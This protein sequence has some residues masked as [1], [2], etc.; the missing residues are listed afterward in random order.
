MIEQEPGI[1]SSEWMLIGRQVR[2]D[3][4]GIIDLIAI[5][6]DGSLVVIELKRDRTPRDVLAQALDYATWVERLEAADIARIYR[7]YTKGRSLDADFRERFGAPLEEESLGDSHQIVIVAAQ[8]DAAT[9]RIVDYLADR[10]ITINVILFQ[11]FEH[12]GEQLLSRAWLFD[13][14]ETQLEAA[15][16]SREGREKEPWNGEFYV[17]FGPSEIRPWEDARRFGFVSAGGGVWYTQTLGLLSEGDRIWVKIPRS[18]FVGVGRVTQP[19]ADLADFT[20]SVDGVD[21]P[22]IEV[23]SNADMLNRHADHPEKAERFVRVEWI[24]TVP[25]AQAFDEVGLFGNQNTVCRPRT[26]KWRETVERLK[27]V[28]P[29]HD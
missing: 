9:E 14:A 23:L 22:A 4:G 28:F 29:H 21:R 20:L 16:S 27:Q 18:G 15:S 11:V 1:L 25:E 2:S 17:S 13:P 7:N 24:H 26:G 19:V 8:L 6:P 12:E 5:A 3:H 10:G